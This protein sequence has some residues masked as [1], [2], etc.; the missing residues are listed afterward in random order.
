MGNPT[1]VGAGSE[2]I[3]PAV[4]DTVCNG[5]RTG[6]ITLPFVEANASAGSDPNGTELSA[7]WESPWAQEGQRWSEYG[8]QQGQQWSHYGQEQ[9]QQWSHYG[10]EQGQR[11]SQYGQDWAHSYG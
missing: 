2:Q 10:Q 7:S 8:R 6:G 9:G 11:W 1:C 4:K 3:P 5:S